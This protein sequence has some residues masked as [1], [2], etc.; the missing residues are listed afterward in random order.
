[1]AQEA[2]PWGLQSPPALVGCGG[3]VEVSPEARPCTS[4][5]HSRA[6]FAT[7][8][9]PPASALGRKSWRPLP[10]SPEAHPVPSSSPAPG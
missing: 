2:C 6:V 1:V 5:Q 4:F 7:S 8:P 9:P 10:G 3:N